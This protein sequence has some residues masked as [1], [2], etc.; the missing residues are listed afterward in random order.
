MIAWPP[1]RSQGTGWSS[2]ERGGEFG[3]VSYDWSNDK[4]D[5]AMAQPMD[6]E[7]RLLHQAKLTHAANPDSKV[8]VYRN[9]V[10]AMPWFTSVREKLDDPNYSGWFLKFD[11]AKYKNKK[12]PGTFAS[13]PCDANFFLKPAPVSPL[14]AGSMLGRQ[15]GSMTSPRQFE[16]NHLTY[17]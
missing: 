4:D 3:I 1:L 5:W 13:D 11:P 17:M 12:I 15:L 10:W 7:E 9:L 6:A 16:F 14:I 8:F 2:P